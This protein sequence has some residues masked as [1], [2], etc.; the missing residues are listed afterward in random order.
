MAHFLR[1]MAL[2]ALGG[3]LVL[4]GCGS[5]GNPTAAHSS[6]HLVSH[7]HSGVRINHFPWRYITGRQPRKGPIWCR[8][9]GSDGGLS[10]RRFDARLLLALRVAAAGHRAQGHGC[11]TRIVMV[12][13]HGRAITDDLRVNRVNLVISSGFV[14]GVDVF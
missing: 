9:L 8:G 12:N 6:P 5:S 2:V 10:G 3:V 7:D 14:T 4:A 11:T 13:G 1:L